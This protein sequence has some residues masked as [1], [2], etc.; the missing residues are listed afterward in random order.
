MANLNLIDI[1]KQ[2]G[3]DAAVGL[4]EESIQAHPELNGAART[5]AG[6]SYTALIRESLPTIGFRNANEGATAVKSVWKQKLVNT[7]IVD[8]PIEVD[9]AVADAAEDGPEVV[10]AREASGVMEGVMRSLASQMYYGTATTVATSAAGSPTK[11]FPGLVE[12][13]NTSIS[14]DKSGTGSDTSSV[15]AVK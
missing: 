11:G 14:V 12:T 1:A 8:A 3:N 2:N 15:W 9:K 4:I 6:T 10:I 13:Y 7:F 5:I